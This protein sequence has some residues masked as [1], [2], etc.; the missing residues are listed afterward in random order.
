MIL[1]IGEI[2][3]D[4]LL[5]GIINMAEDNNFKH[6]RNEKETF[7]HGDGWGIGYLLNDQILVKKSIKEIYSKKNRTIKKYQN[8]KSNI[9]MIHARKKSVGELSKEN[10]HPF[11]RSL[12]KEKFVFCHNGTV[13]SGFNI[14]RFKPKGD[15]DSEKLFLTIINK[16]GILQKKEP[17]KNNQKENDLIIKAIK[18]VLNSIQ[19]RKGTNIF[20]SSKDKIYI[21]LKDCAMPKYYE[22]WI[23]KQKD[24]LIISSEKLKCATQFNWGKIET[25]KILKIDNKNLNIKEYSL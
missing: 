25:G 13:I 7:Q 24:N 9:C 2:E 23:A 12:K 18:E 6:E 10:C 4:I 11:S 3:I 20:F 22:M 21:G 16:I 15:T 5:Q 8:L 19:T 14:G 17:I 1:G